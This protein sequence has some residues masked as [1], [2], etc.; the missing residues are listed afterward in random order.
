LFTE[1]ISEDISPEPSQRSTYRDEEVRPET[2]EEESETPPIES[3]SEG[4]VMAPR[5]SKRKQKPESKPVSRFNSNFS[6]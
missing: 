4:L 2:E 1:E 3:D 5:P 6:F